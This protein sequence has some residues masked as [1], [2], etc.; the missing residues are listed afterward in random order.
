MADAIAFPAKTM[1]SP[2]PTLWRILARDRIGMAGAVLIVLMVLAALL[3]PYVS[4]YEPTRIHSGARLLP[5]GARFW[6]GTD[7]LGRDLLSRALYGARI[8]LQVSL[9]VVACATIIGVVIGIVAGYMRGLFD[10]LAM[11]LMDILF[12]FP[13]I[14]LALAVVAI[15]GTNI[16][17]LIIALTIVYIPTFARIAR[18]AALSVSNEVYVEAAVSVGVGHRRILLRHVLPNIIAP[19]AVQ[20]TIALAYVILVESSLSYLGL[21]VQPPQASWGSMLASGKVHMER[22]LWP[23][24]VPGLF[25]VA[26]VLG[27]NLLGDALRDSLDPQMRSSIR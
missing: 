18:A 27:F 16:E 5:P 25:I 7:E 6:L 24:L 2:R 17:N 12:A 20:V 13:T 10:G 26:T 22:S 11:R 8:S 23:S 21:G 15:L 9:A 19:I 1:A 3:A 4:P 14:L